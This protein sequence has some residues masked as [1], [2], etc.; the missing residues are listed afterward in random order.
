M[1]KQEMTAKER[2]ANEIIETFENLIQKSFEIEKEITKYDFYAFKNDL[3]F[4]PDEIINMIK[5]LRNQYFYVKENIK[6]QM[7]EQ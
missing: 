7:I 4:Y 5:Q 2:V 3:Y 1:K 6:N